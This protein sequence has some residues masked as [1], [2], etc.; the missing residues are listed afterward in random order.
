[1]D[2]KYEFIRSDEVFESLVIG[3]IRINGKKVEKFDY[4]KN[5]KTFA[6]H[7]ER[8]LA[9]IILPNGDICSASTRKIKIWDRNSQKLVLTLKGHK[10]E[11]YNLAV[12]KNG[13]LCS[14]SMDKIIKIWN[15]ETGK[16]FF[17]FGYDHTGGIVGLVLLPNGFL[18]SSAED[19]TVRIWNMDIMLSLFSFISDDLVKTI[20]LCNTETVLTSLVVLDEENIFGCSARDNSIEIVNF[21]TERMDKGLYGHRDS[22]SNIAKCPN[23]NFVSASFDRTIKI[24]G[25]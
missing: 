21:K 2:K 7:T 8:I 20:H 11:I 23:G 1:M 5:I 13:N 9:L 3:S 6:A 15:T 24:W 14:C 10:Q 22:V 19:Y 25:K 17:E 4:I 18:C 12:L 16:L